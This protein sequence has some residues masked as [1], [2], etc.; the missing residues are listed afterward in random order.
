MFKASPGPWPHPQL[1]YCVLT[2]PPRLQSILKLCGNTLETPGRGSTSYF[3]LVNDLCSGRANLSAVIEEVEA[4][5]EIPSV[6]ERCRELIEDPNELVTAYEYVP[7]RLQSFAR[8]RGRAGV[9][10][11]EMGVVLVVTGGYRSWRLR[12]KW[13]GLA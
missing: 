7:G 13:E 10:L 1:A 11:Y 8:R 12:V 5:L 9:K 2:P 4:I 6:V 3:D